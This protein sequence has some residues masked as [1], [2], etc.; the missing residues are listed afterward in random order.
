[1]HDLKCK[2]GKSCKNTVAHES[3]LFEWIAVKQKTPR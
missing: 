1:M 2:A 3:V